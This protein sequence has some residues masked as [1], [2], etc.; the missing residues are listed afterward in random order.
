MVEPHGHGPRAQAHD[1]RPLL[2]DVIQGQRALDVRP[3]QRL[4]TRKGIQLQGG[5]NMFGC[6]Q[7]RMLQGRE[8]RMKSGVCVCLSTGVPG[9]YLRARPRLRRENLHEYRD[10]A[11]NESVCSFC[12]EI[13]N[14]IL[15]LVI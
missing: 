6:A 9:D 12:L 13:P 8:E 11:S 5:A 7:G 4:A 1:E 15:K 3:S 14:R 10:N 2:R